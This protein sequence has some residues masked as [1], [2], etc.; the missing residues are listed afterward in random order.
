MRS[1]IITFLFG[2]SLFTLPWAGVGVIHFFTHRDVGGGLQP[3]WVFLGLAILVFA[4]KMIPSQTAGDGQLSWKRP[5]ALLVYLTLGILASVAVSGVGI[6]LVPS[7]ESLMSAWGRLTRQLI[8]LIIM[9][10]FLWWAALWV[11]NNRRWQLTLDFI[12]LG[13]LCQVLYSLF[14]GVNFFLPLFWFSQLEAFFTSNPSILSGSEKLYL[15]NILQ[16]IPR[17]RGTVCEPLYL[18]NYL[19]MVW[20]FLLVWRRKLWIRLVLGSLFLILLVL[21]W[22]RGAWLGFMGQLLLLGLVFL[23]AK[24]KRRVKNS[25]I[26]KQRKTRFIP[27]GLAGLILLLAAGDTLGGGFILHRLLATFNNQD[28]SNLTRLYSMKAAWMAFLES[29][30]VGIGWGQFAFH[31]PL[32]VDPM[33]LQSQFSWP[34][35][36]NFPLQILCETGLIGF[37]VFS[38]AGLLLLRMSCRVLNRNPGMSPMGLMVVPAMIS[39]WGV[40]VQLMSFSQYNL[41]HIWIGLGLLIAALLEDPS[42]KSADEPEGIK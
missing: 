30:V 35:V 9:L 2:L 8:Q 16:E 18:G 40:W 38:G 20:P 33:G 39:V 29:P 11:N 17:M 36:N 1:T 28:W 7:L 37:A 15:N 23:V 27:A 19:L 4:L 25:E 22:S 6:H 3:S 5:P 26:K 31:F 42:E 12:F 32:L 14:Q 21:T 10:S 41:P 34:V 24:I 13:A